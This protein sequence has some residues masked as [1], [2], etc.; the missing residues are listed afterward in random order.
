[1][2]VLF[3]TDGS[4]I[5]FRALRNFSKWARNA[6]IDA[7]CVVDW[8]FLPD[9]VA[10]EDSRFETSCAN[11]AGSILEKVEFETE[12]LGMTFR[13]KIRY[14]GETVSGILEQVQDKKYDLILMGSHGKKGLQ[15]WLGSVSRDIVNNVDTA[16]YITKN[17][18]ECKKVL[19]AADGSSN[20][21]FAASEAIKYLNL[22]DKE[23]YIV[24]VLE[25]PNLLFLEGALDSRWLMEIEEQ[26]H[27]YATRI[28]L[29]VQDKLKQ[30]NLKAD[31]FAILQ[32]NP[33]EKI[34]EF[35][36]KEEIDLIITGTRHSAQKRFSGSVSKR[37][38]EIAPSDVAIFK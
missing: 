23:I 5:S 10:I 15:R 34:S 37:I 14:C 16:T 36:K 2:N 18:N 3:C 11:V 4:E 8:S 31:K 29:E 33:A 35:A 28:I 12:E 24:I 27:K 25:S 13:D 21:R 26:Q 9:S 6:E 32:G 20:S 1:M 7:I 17:K 38:L 19:F 30:Y 22:T